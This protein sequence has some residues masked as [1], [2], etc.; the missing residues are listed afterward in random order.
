MN[1]IHVCLVSEQTI[2][3]ILSL[4]HNQPDRIIFCTSEKME[5]LGKSDAIIN[6]LK[7]YG[8]DYSSK[9]DRVLV[10]QD[11]LEDCEA[12]LSNI[13]QKYSNHK[14]VVNLTGGTKIMVLGAYNVFKS[15]ENTQMIYTPIPKN[16]F[17]EVF[18]RKGNCK[19]PI[20]LTL[21][22][23]VEAYV[24]AYGVKIK[25]RSKLEQLKSDAIKNRENSTWMIRNY[26]AIEGLLCCF[27]K[28]KWVFVESSG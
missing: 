17:I 9:F 4:Y 18:P 5:K 13:A 16:E 22:L 12:R 19:S 27:I 23:S 2:P 6:T 14:F 26:E 24:S 7:L 1:H 3:N 8:L 15:I 11:C 10:D 21:R 28:E 20:P 25:N